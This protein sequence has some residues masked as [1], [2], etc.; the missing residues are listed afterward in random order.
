MSDPLLKISGISKKFGETIAVKS[1]SLD[2]KTGEILGLLG[3]NGAGKS[4]LAKILV[5]LIKPDTGKILCFGKQLKPTESLN[6]KLI[7]MV[8]Q[9]PSFY[10]SLQ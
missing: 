10:R 4:T 1:V 3:P 5:G 6:K 8:P 2:I 9:E 7:A